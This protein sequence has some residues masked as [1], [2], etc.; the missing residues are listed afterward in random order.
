LFFAYPILSNLISVF[1][2]SLN[3]PLTPCEKSIN[4]KRPSLLMGQ[5]R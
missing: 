4:K 3:I 2:H 5:P 1:T